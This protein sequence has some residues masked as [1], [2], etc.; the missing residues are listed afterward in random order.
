ML[1]TWLTCKPL[2][3]IDITSG[4][5][6]CDEPS[7]AVRKLESNIRLQSSRIKEFI[8]GLERYLNSSILQVKFLNACFS[9]S[10]TEYS[11]YCYAFMMQM[12]SNSMYSLRWIFNSRNIIIFPLL[13][14]KNVK[15]YGVNSISFCYPEAE[16]FISSRTH[17]CSVLIRQLSRFC[18]PF[19]PLM[20]RI[21]H[22]II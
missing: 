8:E 2:L 9:S 10:G 22:Q 1:T 11:R 18:R 6:L 14:Q 12:W 5:V 7:R 13:S 19:V 21:C 15:T 16:V 4:G 20:T 17:F 3:G